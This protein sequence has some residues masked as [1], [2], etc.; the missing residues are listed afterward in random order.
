MPNKYT[1]QVPQNEGLPAQVGLPPTRKPQGGE[2]DGENAL[3]GE[4]DF[5]NRERLMGN[6]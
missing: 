6:E 3:L 5:M 2:Q 1:D 4:A